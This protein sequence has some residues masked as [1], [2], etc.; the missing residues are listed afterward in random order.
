MN[1]RVNE[2]MKKR[3]RQIDKKIEIEQHTIK[4]YKHLF[5]LEIIFSK[6]SGNSCCAQIR[7][8]QMIMIHFPSNRL[9]I[10][11]ESQR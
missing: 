6:F 4:L 1:F 9:R 7:F 5:F 3:K 8:H 2:R 10:P 11:I